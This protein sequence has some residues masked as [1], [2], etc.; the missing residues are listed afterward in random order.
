LILFFQPFTAPFLPSF[1][2]EEPNNNNNNNNN[3]IQFNSLLFM[4]RVSSHKAN[5]RQ[6][7]VNKSNYNMDNHNIKSKSN[8]RHALEENT[9]MQRS[10]QTKTK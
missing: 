7:S 3:T 1:Q 10:K 9:L 5:Y 2:G 6:H 4:C 8:Y